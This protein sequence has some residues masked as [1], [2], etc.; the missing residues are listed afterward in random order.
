MNRQ[1]GISIHNVGIDYI[2]K[3]NFS[4]VQLCHKFSGAKEITSLLKLSKKYPVKVSY[5]APVFYQ[6]DPTVTY[7]LNSNSRLRDATFEILEIN[8]KMAKSLPTDHVVVHFASKDIDNKVSDKELLNLAKES[9]KRLDNLSEKY[10]VPIYLEY[11]GYNNRFNSPEEWVNLVRDS[12]NLGLCLDIGHLYISCKMNGMDYFKELEKMLPT[13][14]AMHI[15]NTRGLKDYERYGHIPVHP[16][17]KRENGWID[18][19]ET[20]NIV[21]NYN[22]KIPVIFE[23]DFEYCDIEYAQEGIEWVNE[24]VYNITKKKRVS[25]DNV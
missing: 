3:N 18:I 11:V 12:K 16:S 6:V 4:I 8:L 19:E 14:K 22:N 23:P 1:L 2:R 7:Y 10:N 9:A 21:L 24:L 20:L 17:Q 15:W 25:L 5:H 13:I